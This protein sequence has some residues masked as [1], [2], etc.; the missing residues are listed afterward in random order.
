MEIWFYHLTTR[1]LET[2]LPALLERSLARGWKAVV[3]GVSKERIDHLDTT[4]WTYSDASFLPHGTPR[5]GDGPLQQVF[6]T[7]G[8]ENPNEAAIRFFVE[9]ASCEDAL[10]ATP[11]YERLVLMFDVSDAEQLQSARENW[12]R[13]KSEGHAISYWQQNDDGRW[14]KKA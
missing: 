4:L 6:L 14:Q 11:P 1:P 10:R 8:S 12:R 2:A 7:T 3:Q 9:G 13:L 5:D